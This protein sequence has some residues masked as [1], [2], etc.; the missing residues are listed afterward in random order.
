M[1]QAPG[2]SPRVVRNSI[3]AP[4]RNTSAPVP[5]VTSHDR[6][7]RRSA[8]RGPAAPRAAMASVDTVTAWPSSML[9]AVERPST[10]QVHAPAL[11]TVPAGF[12]VRH[13]STR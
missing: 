8:G 9:M 11:Q 10:G 12:T 5:T 6:D 3:V 1:A 7:G 2:P 13:Q 4:P